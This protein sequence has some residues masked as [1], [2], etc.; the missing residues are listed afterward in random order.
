MKMELAGHDQ[1]RADDAA[2][3]GAQVNGLVQA[4]LPGF[5]GGQVCP[6]DPAHLGEP[7]RHLGLIWFG[8]VEGQDRGHHLFHFGRISG[9]EQA[10]GPGV[11]DGPRFGI[12]PARLACRASRASASTSASPPS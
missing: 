9:G 6:H 2:Q 5:S 4:A 10:L 7:C 8:E 3:Q 1:G 11:H 12:P